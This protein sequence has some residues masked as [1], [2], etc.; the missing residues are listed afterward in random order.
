VTKRRTFEKKTYTSMA[1][2]QRDWL[3][4]FRQA[5][6]SAEKDED[7]RVDKFAYNPH[8]PHNGPRCIKCGEGWC[9][10]CTGPW[11]IAEQ[12]CGGA[13]YKRRVKREAEDRVLA[14]AAAIRKRRRES[15]EPDHA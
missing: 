15:E 3:T 12:K 5:G 7:G 6:H 11:D 1:E 9:W 8:D 10:H 4:A 14:E 2:Y 13:E